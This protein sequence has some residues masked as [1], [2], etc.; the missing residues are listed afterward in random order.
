[1]CMHVYVCVLYRHPAEKRSQNATEQ[2]ESNKSDQKTNKELS[3]TI[4]SNDVWRARSVE[5]VSK[6]DV[7]N[8]NKDRYRPDV[9]ATG[10]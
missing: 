3:S 4:C 2:W 7:L 5:A 9:H 1:M 6:M 10:K 8:K